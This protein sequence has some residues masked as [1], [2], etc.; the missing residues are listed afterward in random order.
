MT[1]DGSRASVFASAPIMLTPPALHKRKLAPARRGSFCSALPLPVRDLDS[2]AGGLEPVVPRAVESVEAMPQ[3]GTV[4]PQ[5]A[6][7]LRYLPERICYMPQVLRCVTRV[8]TALRAFDEEE[9]AE[10]TQQWVAVWLCFADMCSCISPTC[11]DFRICTC[12]CIR[13]CLFAS[14]SSF[15]IKLSTKKRIVC[16]ISFFV[17]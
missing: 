11:P 9:R 5:I 3:S 6:A 15:R 10:S 17:A 16:A 4:I 13:M 14:L 8:A 12:H 7:R 1:L 2:I